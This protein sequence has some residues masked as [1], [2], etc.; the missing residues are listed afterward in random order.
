ML[1]AVATSALALGL[2]VLATSRGTFSQIIGILRIENGIALFE[3]GG[4]RDHDDAAIRVGMT[5][6]L[7][8]SI[9]FYR[10]YLDHVPAGDEPTSLTDSAAL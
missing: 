10:W 3:L 5:T 1:V 8:V 6:I 2:F 4:H 9:L 7:L